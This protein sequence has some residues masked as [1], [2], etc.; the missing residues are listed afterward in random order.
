MK[1]FNNVYNTAHALKS[2]HRKKIHNVAAKWPIT[3]QFVFSVTS[4]DMESSCRIQNG[5]F[6]LG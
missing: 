3:S 6:A 1:I 4:A 2:Y 5:A